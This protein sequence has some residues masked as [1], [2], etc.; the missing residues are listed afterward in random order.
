MMRGQ[1]LLLVLVLGCSGSSE[2]ERTSCERAIK[3]CG[4]DEGMDSCIK[5][6][7]ETKDAMGESYAKFLECSSAAENCGEYLGC[8]VG[9]IG[10]EGMKQLDGMRRGMQKMMGDQLRERLR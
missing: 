1:L 5:D 6:I 10:V 9:G 2:K 7:Q 8:A 3:L 4:Y